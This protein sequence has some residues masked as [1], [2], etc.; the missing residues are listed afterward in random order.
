MMDA[1]SQ[2]QLRNL[3]R[4]KVMQKVFKKEPQRQLYPKDGLEHD[5]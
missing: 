2:V 5:K 1:I 3:I 4:N